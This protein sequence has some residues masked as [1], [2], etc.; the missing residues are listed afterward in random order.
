MLG[1]ELLAYAKAGDYGWFAENFDACVSAYGRKSPGRCC[2]E[3]AA[4]SEE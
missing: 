1:V 4:R 2:R 3:A